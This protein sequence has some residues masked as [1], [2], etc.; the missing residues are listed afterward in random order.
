MIV[1]KS[2]ASFKRLTRTPPS[3]FIERDGVKYTLTSSWRV[4][5]LGKVQLSNLA[6]RNSGYT[7]HLRDEIVRHDD[8][9]MKF[10]IPVIV[11]D[12]HD[13]LFLQEGQKIKQLAVKHF[14]FSNNVAFPS[15]TIG[16]LSIKYVRPTYYCQ[17]IDVEPRCGCILWYPGVD[18][19]LKHIQCKR[20]FYNC[21]RCSY[22]VIG[23]CYKTESMGISC[24]NCMRASDTGP[25]SIIPK[26]VNEHA[27][28]AHCNGS[29]RYLSTLI[30][31][32]EFHSRNPEKYISSR[33]LPG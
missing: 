11:Y 21:E 20:R 29:V 17:K 14:R 19:D 16:S 8:D 3:I 13:Y 10:G 18:D 5:D 31:A 22:A 25:F 33:L 24:T 23:T 28:R 26:N 12:P 15:G 4:K 9:Y 2:H 6:T 30:Y 27:L 7:N 1:V 32:A